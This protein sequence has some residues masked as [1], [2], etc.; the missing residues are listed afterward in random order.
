ML[1]LHLLTSPTGPRARVLHHGV[2]L[3]DYDDIDA[4]GVASQ[5]VDPRTIGVIAGIL[6]STTAVGWGYAQFRG[7]LPE[8][9]LAGVDPDDI[10]VHGEHGV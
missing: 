10:E 6:S 9:P 5:S 8:P 4:A 1:N 7:L 3:G 2:D